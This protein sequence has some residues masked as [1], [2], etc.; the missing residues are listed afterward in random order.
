MGDGWNGVT[1]TSPRPNGTYHS[2]H[3]ANFMAR[4][5]WGSN[6][7]NPG[8]T[9]PRIYLLAIYHPGHPYSIS[10]VCCDILWFGNYLGTRYGIA[11]KNFSYPNSPPG[12]RVGKNDFCW[13]ARIKSGNRHL[14]LYPDS[15][16]PS[17]DY[18]ILD[19]WSGNY[20]NAWRQLFYR[21]VDDYCFNSKNSRAVHGNR[22]NYYP[23]AIFRL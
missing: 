11:P 23:A 5:F 13:Y 21:L 18:T 15:P 19:F 2:G 4:Y 17:S 12:T 20:Y 10:N 22:A 3:P 1:K 8:N 16:N 7:Q 14:S 6:E 9:D